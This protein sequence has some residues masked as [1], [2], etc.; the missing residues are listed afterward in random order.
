MFEFE[1][2]AGIAGGV[3]IALI[4]WWVVD[5]QRAQNRPHDDAATAT[6]DKA[7]NDKAL[8][9]EWNPRVQAAHY[10][11]ARARSLT[12]LARITADHSGW[13]FNEMDELTKTAGGERIAFTIEDAADTMQDLGWLI[14]GA[15]SWGSMPHDNDS[16]AAAV[17][18]LSREARAG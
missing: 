13:H 11:E 14:P 8:F 4:V 10:T 15:V 18:C 16:R 1:F 5:R 17:T 9:D 7:G 6:R 2:F 12:E 3:G